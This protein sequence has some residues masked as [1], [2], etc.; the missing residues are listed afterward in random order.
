MEFKPT[1]PESSRSAFTLPEVII[2]SALAVLLLL[3][4]MSFYVFSL[5][6]FASMANYADLNA[7]SRAAS[8]W[9]TRDVRAATSVASA[10]TNQLV[11]NA[12]DGTNV[13]LNF[14]PAAGK[15]TRTKGS[16]SRTLLK[17]VTSLSFS[18]YQRPTNNSAAYEQFPPAIAANAKLVAFQWSCSRRVSGPQNDS[19]TIQAAMVELRNQ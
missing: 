1:N 15:L 7:Q 9:I 4:A 13:T 10:T 16:E 19:E 12:F 5:S 8:D 2:S 6:S 18:L 11:L 17:D 3:G 14:D